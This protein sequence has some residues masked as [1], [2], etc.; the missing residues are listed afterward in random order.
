[1]DTDLGQPSWETW[2]MEVLIPTIVSKSSLKLPNI[3]FYTTKF[4]TKLESYSWKTFDKSYWCKAWYQ[5]IQSQLMDSRTI[6]LNLMLGGYY[7][8][9]SHERHLVVVKYLS[10]TSLFIKI[11]KLIFKN[12]GGVIFRDWIPNLSFTTFGWTNK[13]M[14]V[15]M[16]FVPEILAVV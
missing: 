7:S 4:S 5:I 11:W 15:V 9:D 10:V 8:Y 3:F 13:N 1:M 12:Y 6:V 16:R 14:F 2:C